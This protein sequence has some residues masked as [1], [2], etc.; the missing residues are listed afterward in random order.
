MNRK[1]AY[2]LSAL[3]F[4]T[5]AGICACAQEPAVQPREAPLPSRP[6]GPATT[7]PRAYLAGPL[8]FSEAGS[9][10][11]YGTL[12]PQ[13]KEAG[14][15]AL[16]PW[17]LT[18]KSVIDSAATLRDCDQRRARFREVVNPTIGRN[19]AEAIKRCDVVIAVLDGSDVDSGTAAEIGYA[20]GLGKIILGYRS[21]SRLS[22]DNEGSV[23][24]LQVEYFIRHSG[25]DIVKSVGLLRQALVE[26]SKQIA[27]GA[28]RT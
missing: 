7:K 24:N 26:L 1:P 9:A 15:E 27:H 22:A 20:A 16:D 10:Y 3:A 8:G 2:L 13:V 12:V 18:P 28:K 11:Y 4:L 5:A 23:V 25:G 19:N 17:T 6:A 14:F 21:D